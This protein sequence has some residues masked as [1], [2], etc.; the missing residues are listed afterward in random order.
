MRVILAVGDTAD[1]NFKFVPR[2]IFVCKIPSLA[3]ALGL[4]AKRALDDRVSKIPYRR[5]TV[6]CIQGAYGRFY[7]IYSISI[8]LYTRYPIVTRALGLAAA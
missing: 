3:R 5:D 1:E 7:L 8:P 6:S 4:K 2:R